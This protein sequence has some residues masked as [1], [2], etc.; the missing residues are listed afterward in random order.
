MCPPLVE[1]TERASAEDDVGRQRR[2][3]V[4]ERAGEVI[5][6]DHVVHGV[7]LHMLVEEVR[8]VVAV[9]EPSQ[10]VSV[11][12]VRTRRAELERRQVTHGRSAQAPMQ[13]E[14]GHEVHGREGDSRDAVEVRAVGRV[15]PEQPHRLTEQD[16]VHPVDVSSAVL[17]RLDLDQRGLGAAG[18]PRDDPRMRI[19]LLQVIGGTVD[20]ELLVV[21]ELRLAAEEPR[22]RRLAA[23][24]DLPQRVGDIRG[25]DRRSTNLVAEGGL[26]RT[27]Q[28]R[29]ERQ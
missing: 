29:A 1:R 6:G 16:R 10:A 20:Q 8:D 13:P 19:G 28:R 12:A 3:L 24:A 9:T 22:H 18:D 7:R 26:E 25:S 4:R 11:E 27:L 14:Q 17:I 21:P 15:E 5:R 2:F 23:L